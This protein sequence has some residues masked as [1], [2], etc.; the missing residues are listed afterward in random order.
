MTD[1]NTRYQM[2][3][4]SSVGAVAVGDF[5][6][7]QGA[8]IG[9]SVA[10]TTITDM[11]PQNPQ[12]GTAAAGGSGPRPGA[13]A[14]CPPPGAGQQA[15]SGAGNGTGGGGF[16]GGTVQQVNGPTIT[17]DTVRGGPMTLT[18]DANT[19]VM[20]RQQGQFSD[21]RVGDQVMAMAGRG[22]GN[23]VVNSTPVT[24]FTAALV[25]DDTAH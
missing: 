8:T 9:N 1:T 5:V 18:T 2:L 7:A 12:G 13:R 15:G 10:V 23:A 19:K 25:T 3:A 22:N 16:I 20:R 21:L 14:G 6:T 24:G 11:G 17:I 4:P